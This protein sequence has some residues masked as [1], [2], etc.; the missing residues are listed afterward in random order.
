MYT[1]PIRLELFNVRSDVVLQFIRVIL[2][3]YLWIHMH[4][5][6]ICIT[7]QSIS[8]RYCLEDID[9]WFVGFALSEL[10]VRNNQVIGTSSSCTYIKS[11]LCFQC[12]HKNLKHCRL[13]HPITKINCIKWLP[14]RSQ[15]LSDHFSD[16]NIGVQRCDKATNRSQ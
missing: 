3:I 16:Q 4:G 12:P 11:V 1:W 14:S 7:D 5:L 8:S 13:F 9:K 2:F 15:H 10:I 6:R